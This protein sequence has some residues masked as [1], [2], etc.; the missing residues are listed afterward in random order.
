MA[1]RTFA[2]LLIAR[3]FSAFLLFPEGESADEVDLF[4]ACAVGLHAR[5]GRAAAA[6]D[7]ARVV[8]FGARRQR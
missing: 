2:E 7:R 8:L 5:R 4:G 3:R 1:C 6:R